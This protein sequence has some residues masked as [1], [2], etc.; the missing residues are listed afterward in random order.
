MKHS[1]FS[2]LPPSLL[3]RNLPSRVLRPMN[4][5]VPQQVEFFF[6]FGGKARNGSE[7]E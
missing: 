5:D 4:G 1:A 2:D 3:R 7:A 6:F